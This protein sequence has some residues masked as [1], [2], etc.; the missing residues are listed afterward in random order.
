MSRWPSSKA[1][2]VR[3]ALAKIG[4]KVIRSADGSHET[5]RR[6]GWPDFVWAFHDADELGPVILAKIAKKTGLKPEDL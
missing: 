6:A 5:L 4:W 3:R 1:K 2:R